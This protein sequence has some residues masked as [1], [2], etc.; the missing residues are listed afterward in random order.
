MFRVY[1]IN[2]LAEELK[3]Q[4][5]RVCDC[6]EEMSILTSRL[7]GLSEMFDDYTSEDRK[8]KRFDELLNTVFDYSYQ[9]D[10]LCN[11]YVYACDTKTHL[12][13]ERKNE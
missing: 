8:L 10:C 3:E 13:S 2:K 9:L 12:V 4:N 7:R 1:D 6:F 5:D 11:A